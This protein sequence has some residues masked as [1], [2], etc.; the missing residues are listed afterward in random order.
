M[1]RNVYRNRAGYQHS[2]SHTSWQPSSQVYLQGLQA[3]STIC[4]CVTILQG[5]SSRYYDTQAFTQASGQSG[6]ASDDGHTAGGRAS[7]M[8]HALMTH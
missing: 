2:T 4:I 8:D 1:A 5:T 3:P 6:C 7:V